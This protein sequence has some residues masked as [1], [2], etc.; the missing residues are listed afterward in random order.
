VKITGAIWLIWLFSCL[1]SF[2]TLE[3]IALWNRIPNDTLT[4]VS[5]QKVPWYVGLAGLVAGFILAIGHWWAAYRD[6]DGQMR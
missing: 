1:V 5:S 4:A 6:K 3:G 2:L